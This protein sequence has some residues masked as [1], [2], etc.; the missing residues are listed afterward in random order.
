MIPGV[1]YAL[2]TV[3]LAAGAILKGGVYPQHWQ[4]IALAVGVGSLLAVIKSRPFPAKSSEPLV[5]NILLAALLLWMTF[6]L[7]PLPAP[8]VAWLSPHRWSDLEQARRMTGQPLDAWAPLSLAPPATLER[9]LYVASAMA[10]FVA[11]RQLAWL[12]KDRLWMVVAPVV[13]IATFESLLGLIRYYEMKLAGGRIDAV[14]GT[15]VNRNHFAGLLELALPLALLW[16]FSIWR[17]GATRLERSFS[18][19]LQS[20]SLFVVGACLLA[21]MVASQSRMAFLSTLVALGFVLFA[22]LVPPAFRSGRSRTWRWAIPIC[23]PLVLLVLLPTHEMAGR[24]SAIA[25]GGSTDNRMDI[26]NNTLQMLPSYR[27]T[28][29]G[30]GTYERSM[31]A[32]KTVAPTNTLDFAHNDYLQVLGEFG[33][34]GALLVG[35]LFAWT[36]VRVLQVA[37]G[38]RGTE[39]R[40][41]AVGLAAA[42]LA[43]SIHSLADFNLYIPANALAFAWLAGVALSPGLRSS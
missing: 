26:W 7:V 4:W 35:G 19:G 30:L 23:V 15:Y 9:L 43:F 8:A 2:L 36:F 20:A 3:A 10:M 18:A 24:L 33:V 11:A 34:P 38:R 25:T 21:G 29:S 1:A 12:W 16:A 40:E 22:V 42:L 28:G 14:T 31:Y 37:F 6:G 13:G 32:F 39:H 41:L 27:L 17:K 5:S